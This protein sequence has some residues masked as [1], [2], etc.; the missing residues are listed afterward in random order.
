M[1]QKPI[2][3]EMHYPRWKHHPTKESVLVKDKAQEE[4]LGSGW[5]ESLAEAKAIKEEL[6]AQAASDGQS[7][8]EEHSEAPG[9]KRGRPKKD[10][11][12]E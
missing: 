4:K 3:P 12:E 10:Q 11:T 5:L 2:T 8:S 7:E 6:E 9:K 1:E